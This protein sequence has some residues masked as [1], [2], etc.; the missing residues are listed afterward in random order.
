MNFKNKFNLK[1][2]FYFH[3]W[4][5]DEKYDCSP[6]REIDANELQPNKYIIS[7]LVR[8]YNPKAYCSDMAKKFDNS[9][10]IDTIAYRNS[11][12]TEIQNVSNLLS[13][14]YSRYRVKNLIKDHAQR[15]GDYDI[16]ILSRFDFL[17]E[18][19]IDPTSIDIEKI[20]VSDLHKDRQVFP[21][22][23]IVMAKDK[24]IKLFNIYDELHQLID[25]YH[26]ENKIKKLNEKLKI[27]IEEIL[28]ASF[29]YYNEHENIVRTKLVP[30]FM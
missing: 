1:L 29:I 3:T 30:N 26:L 11:S 5:S 27:N 7:E 25:C 10:V 4:I 15:H 9:K 13:Q 8:L 18:I 28:L 23:F 6:W 2:D 21:D 22:N 12:I 14:L 20:Y 17:K 16:I 19:N 24:F